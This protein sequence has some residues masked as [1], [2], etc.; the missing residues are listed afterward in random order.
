MSRFDF[1]GFFEN[2]DQ[3]ISKLSKLLSVEIDAAI[4]VNRTEASP[5][6]QEVKEMSDCALDWPSC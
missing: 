6:Q 2:R 3:D 5:D 1:I 4:Y